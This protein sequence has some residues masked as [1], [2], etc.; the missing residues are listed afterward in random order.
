MILLLAIL[1][2]AVLNM[3]QSFKPLKSFEWLG[4]VCNLKERSG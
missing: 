4:G 1:Y 2:Y 3:F